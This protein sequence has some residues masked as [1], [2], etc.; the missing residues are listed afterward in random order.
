MSVIACSQKII[1]NSMSDRLFAA[2][3][4]VFYRSSS[5]LQPNRRCSFSVF[6]M[7]Y[8]SSSAIFMAR[9]F[10]DNPNRLMNPSAS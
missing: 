5:S 6:F 8:L 2:I 7:D 1:N 3:H 10:K 4:G 9:T